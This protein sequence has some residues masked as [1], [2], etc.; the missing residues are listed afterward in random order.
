ML[1]NGITQE[2]E[3]YVNATFISP[4]TIL[5]FFIATSKQIEAHSVFDFPLFQEKRWK[6]IGHLTI[7][8]P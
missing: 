8:G 3:V 5:D 2:N 4:L 7:Y 1:N 6:L